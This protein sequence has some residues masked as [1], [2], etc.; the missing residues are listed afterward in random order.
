MHVSTSVAIA[1]P[2]ARVWEILS[3]F[4]D[5]DRWNPLCRDMQG[6]CA[7]GEQIRFRLR[8]GGVRMP[9]TCEVVAAVPGEELRW[10]GPVAPW[11]RRV[12]SGEHFFVLSD[13]DD[14][15]TRV[16]HGEIFR[17]VL[18]AGRWFGGERLLAPT[19][20]ALNRALKREAE[21]TSIARG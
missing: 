14:G 11:A 18:G 16:E 12:T 4:D 15:G 19:Y 17:G 3:R 6:R 10:V 21:T 9:V 2:R 8:V 20:E 13:G 7:E 1:A 5:Y